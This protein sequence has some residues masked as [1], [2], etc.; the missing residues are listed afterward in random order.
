MCAIIGVDT[1][2]VVITVCISRFL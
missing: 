1:H 2:Y